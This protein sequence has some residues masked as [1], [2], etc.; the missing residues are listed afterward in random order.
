M[1]S[2]WP[3]LS[4]ILAQQLGPQRLSRR[5]EPE[6]VTAGAD[7]VVQYDQVMATK[8]VLAYGVGLELV[9]RALPGIKGTGAVDLACGPGHYTLCLCQYLGI[10]K[11][12]GIDLAPRMV[13]VANRNSESR[14]L[15]GSASFCEGDVTR[16]DNLPS[17]EFGLASFTDAAHHMPNL[18]IVASVL[19]EMD[20]ITK[21]DGLVMAM[22][23][24]RLR[25]AKLTERYVETLGREY[26]EQG[27]PRFLDDFHNSMYAA[28]TAEEFFSTIPKD[29]RR[30]W[31]HIVPRGLPTIQVILGLPVGRKEPLVRSGFPWLPH[32][33]PVPENMRAEWRLLRMSLWFASRRFV[34][35]GEGRQNAFP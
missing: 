18:G 16:L 6:Q 27:L 1:G 30:F 15:Q 14:G 28:W 31:C 23:L 26:V 13:A 2:A 32:E 3:F 4:M 20:R 9:Y 8:L 22:D 5:P 29:S 33:N 17:D 12:T 11:I 21:P 19:Q 7:N 35:P 10:H 25:T 24:V 34:R